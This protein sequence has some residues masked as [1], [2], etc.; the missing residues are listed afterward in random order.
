MAELPSNSIVFRIFHEIDTI[1]QLVNSAFRQ[2]LPRPLTLSMF[3]VLNQ[4]V[5]LDEDL[6]P[7]ELALALRISRPSMTV[8]LEKLE[9]AGF[10]GIVPASTDK[11]TK[12]VRLTAAGCEARAR[13]AE[14]TTALI[15]H[16]QSELMEHNQGKLLAELQRLRKVLDEAR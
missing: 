2:V 7:S 9:R 16:I 3:S 12:Q 6:S 10:V 14:A 8:I 5:H 15:E 1:D 4:F 13:A 11:R